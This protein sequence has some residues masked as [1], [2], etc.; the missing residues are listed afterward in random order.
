VSSEKRFSY[1]WSKKGSMIFPEYEGQFFNWIQPLNKD[2]LKGKKILDAGCGMGRNSYWCLKHGA[3]E[4]TAFDNNLN[5]IKA[6]KK[7][8]REFDNKKIEF[9]SIYDID[10]ENEFDFV[11][12]IGVIHHLKYPKLA[13]KNL[14]RALE[15][16]GILLI[17]VYGYENNEW[18]VRYINPIRRITS[19]L[20]TPLTYNLSYLFSVPL[21]IYL[22]TFRQKGKYFRHLKKFRFHHIHLITFDHLLPIHAMYYTKEGAKRLLDG[23]RDIV[24][25]HTNDNS[26]TVMAKK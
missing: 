20:P 22:K 18:V 2:F 16:G 1:E 26:W 11:F 25:I 21:Y 10:Y 24:I 6:A 13:I 23:M 5:T 3:K 4:V 19:H 15:P 12:S 8:L 17:W 14:I 7:N 9:K